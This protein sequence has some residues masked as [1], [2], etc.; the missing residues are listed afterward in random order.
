[1]YFPVV[2]GF[3]IMSAIC[4]RSSQPRSGTTKLNL[5]SFQIFLATT[6]ASIC[7]N[8]NRGFCHQNGSCYV[9]LNYNSMGVVKFCSC[10]D[11]HGCKFYT[12]TAAVAA[13]RCV[14]VSGEKEHHVGCAVGIY[15]IHAVRR[16][17]LQVGMSSRRREYEEPF[18]RGHQFGTA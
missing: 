13:A 10:F 11:C 18:L 2:G 7:A 8:H 9:I 5:W 1:M 12:R 15:I 3:K 16:A 6:A 4:S 17:T 14:V